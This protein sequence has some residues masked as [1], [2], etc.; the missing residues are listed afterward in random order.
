MPGGGS[1]GVSI[2]T[3]RLPDR[4]LSRPPVILVH[5]AAN[6]AAIWTY[7]TDALVAD[8]WPVHAVDLRGHGASAAVDLSYTGMNDYLGD[9][10]QLAEQLRERPVVVGW[11]MGGLVAMMAAAAG[12]ARACIGLAPST[13]ARV[14][15]ERVTLRTG[16]FGPEEYGI[17]DDDPDQQPE[18]PDLDREERLVALG[19]LGRESR[20]ARDERQRGV[21]I[22][23]IPCPLLIVTGTLDRQWPRERYD[24]LHLPAD[25]LV[26]EGA[27]HWGL[28]LNRRA[29]A[30]T[31]PAVLD[32][33]TS[34]SIEL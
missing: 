11:S 17:I 32:W 29:L 19:S 21:V 28:V 30:A 16:E 34:Y 8:G 24:G 18:M 9:V 12:L 33:L 2:V 31:I 20:Y 5:G 15:D 26:A 14:L 25:Y 1:R 4:D 10:R 27:S 6:S 22:T 23:G 3:T 7:W 13:P